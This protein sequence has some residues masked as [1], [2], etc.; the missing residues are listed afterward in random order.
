MLSAQDVPGENMIGHVI[1]DEPLFPESKI[2]Y[3]HPASGNGFGRRR[4]HREAAVGLIG[5]EYEELPPILEITE[6]DERGE[7]YIPE[8]K[9]ERGDVKGAF[10]DCAHILEGSSFSGGQEHFYM[11]S[12]RVR[13]IPVDHDL[14]HLLCATQSTRKFRKWLPT[15]WESPL[16]G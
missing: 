2:M 5:L 15:C 8:R 4:K 6:A 12:Q 10:K 7:W 3:Q 14:I 16:T 13:A 1:K 11:E 9:I